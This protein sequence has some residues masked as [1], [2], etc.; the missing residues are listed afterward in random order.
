MS[1]LSKNTGTRAESIVVLIGAH[2][3]EYHYSKFLLTVRLSNPATTLTNCSAALILIALYADLAFTRFQTD[4]LL[5]R[6]T[7]W[8]VSSNIRTASSL[9]LNPLICFL[10]RFY[11]SMSETVWSKCNYSWVILSKSS[12]RSAYRRNIPSYLTYSSCSDFCNT[13]CQCRHS[14]SDLSIR[15]FIYWQVCSYS[16]ILVSHA[17]ND[18]LRYMIS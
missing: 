8:N 16:A 7:L 5:C 2:A 18:C 4:Y 14:L 3:W 11:P 13:Y 17:L 12:W 6:K 10:P 15:A 9:T 1:Y